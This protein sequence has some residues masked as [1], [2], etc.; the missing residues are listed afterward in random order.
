[1]KIVKGVMVVLIFLLGLLMIGTDSVSFGIF[2]FILASVIFFFMPTKSP[3]KK[4]EEYLKT[5]DAVEIFNGTHVAGLPIGETNCTITFFNDQIKIEG[6]GAQYNISTDKLR[7]VKV[8]QDTEIQKEISSSLVKGVAG[9][10]LFGTAGAI[11]GSRVKT[12]KK[13]EVTLYLIINY[14]NKDN[15]MDSICFD[16]GTYKNSGGN[17]IILAQNDAQQRLK[18]VKTLISK[19]NYEVNL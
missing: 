15:Q 1:M 12:K 14:L 5:I 8:K 10:L 4:R 2:F 17:S 6:G 3:K 11:I 13:L 16:M 9:G 7:D 18:K 19:N